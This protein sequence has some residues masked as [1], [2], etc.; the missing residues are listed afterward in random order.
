MQPCFLFL[1]KA[2]SDE[3]FAAW[4]TH[5]PKPALVAKVSYWMEVVSAERGVVIVQAASKIPFGRLFALKVYVVSFT[6]EAA[7]IPHV[8]VDAIADPRHVSA[9]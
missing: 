6:A 3:R 5:V 8:N 4:P 1:L 9:G 2:T 7:R